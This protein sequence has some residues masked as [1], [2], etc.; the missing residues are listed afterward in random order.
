MAQTGTPNVIANA[1]RATTGSPAT[2]SGDGSTIYVAVVKLTLSVSGGTTGSGA[3]SGVTQGNLVFPARRS[4]RPDPMQVLASSDGTILA[5]LGQ[6]G[7]T[8]PFRRTS[9][10]PH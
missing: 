10:H 6:H 3:M 5:T 1:N 2:I 7:S 8:G 9:W 4:T